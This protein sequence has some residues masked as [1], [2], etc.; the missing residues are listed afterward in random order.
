ML[1]VAGVTLHGVE[2]GQVTRGQAR[3]HGRDLGLGDG[4]G[5]QSHPVGGAAEPVRDVSH[6]SVC[7]AVLGGRVSRETDHGERHQ[8]DGEW[9]CAHGVPP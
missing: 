6:V 7:W 9:V 4:G 2:A 3:V 8:G 1:D 5:K